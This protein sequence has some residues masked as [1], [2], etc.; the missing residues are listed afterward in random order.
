MAHA[1]LGQ[2]GQ[3]IAVSSEIRNA[4]EM[5]S[6]LVLP[7]F[8][9]EFLQP[10]A[11]PAGLA[12]LRA[13]A[14]PLFCAMV[15]PRPE[16]GEEILLQAFE[17]VQAAL[18]SARL[19]LYGIGSEKYARGP[20]TPA[21]GL[22][23]PE[24]RSPKPEARSPAVHGFGELPRPQALALISSCDVFVRPTLADGDSVSVREALALGRAVVA[25]QVGNRPAEVKL[26]APGDA[27]ALA[28]GLLEA[29]GEISLRPPRAASAPAADSL[30]R[31]L[32]LYGWQ[33][34][35]AQ[36]PEEEAPCAASAVS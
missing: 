22:A 12:E 23:T 13:D 24:A 9:R 1:V 11:P 31:I 15:A 36:A 16:Y 30:D 35:A 4:L 14:S 27:G 8:S 19:A 29:A 17:Q 34:P 20:A 7:A 6:A 25:T 21:Q 18:P 32:V 28:K 10:G 26:V 2:F 33:Q 3:V 5:P